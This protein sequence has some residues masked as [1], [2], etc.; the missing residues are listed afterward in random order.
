MQ[1]AS[2]EELANSSLLLKCGFAEGSLSLGCELTI[3]VSQTGR[4]QIIVEMHRLSGRLEVAE[5]H[6]IRVD[7]S[8]QP[9]VVATDIEVGG[10][11]GE[12]EIEGSITLLTI[13]SIGTVGESCHGDISKYTHSVIIL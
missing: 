13:T 7:W 12:Q 2:V 9:S 3:R 5:L 1:W 8:D 11:R 6:D 4:V 10:V